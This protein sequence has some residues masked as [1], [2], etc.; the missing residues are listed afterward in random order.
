MRGKTFQNLLATSALALG[1][2]G[3]ISSVKAQSSPIQTTHRTQVLRVGVV[4]GTQPC[5]YQDSW[6]WEGLAINV[7]SSLAHF[8]SLPYVLIQ[9]PS[10]R[11]LLE[12]TQSGEVDVGV[13][14]INITPERYG[15]YKFTIPIQE[16][17]QGVLVTRKHNFIVPII[18]S[19]V[20]NPAWIRLLVATFISISALTI[21]VWFIEGHHTSV[22]R[23]PRVIAH[24]LV[25]I[26]TILITGEGDSDIVDSTPGRGVILLA[27]IVRGVV[28][29]AIVTVLTVNVL[30][31]I[32]GSMT[33]PVKSLKDLELLKVGFRP[34]TASDDLLKELD[35]KQK[36]EI[37]S[38]TQS[39]DLFAQGK[40]DALVADQLQLEYAKSK[41]DERGVTSLI[42][43][44][45]TNPE[46]QAFAISPKLDL[47]TVNKINLGIIHFKRT[48]QILKHRN[49]ILAEQDNQSCA[50]F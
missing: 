38:I 16:D 44:S 27:W 46:S 2:L 11:S 9:A 21:C 35:V 8:E 6:V 26:F 13:G 12:M 23:H 14:C 40:I 3:S 45:N 7:W 4:D 31:D 43:L 24:R 49:S 15:K 10:T 20:L 19:A 48:G 18:R 28:G 33:M 1:L 42:L 5:S 41:L 36:V 32:K 22:E 50:L 29:A 34:G 47:D 25:K 37:K 30:N 39:I 17:G